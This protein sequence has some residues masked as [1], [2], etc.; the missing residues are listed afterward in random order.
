MRKTLILLLISV[1]F[2]YACENKK[3]E[4]NTIITNVGNEILYRSDLIKILPDEI[5]SNDSA[6][7]VQN[8]INEWRF[9]RLFYNEAI[10]NLE[11]TTEIAEKIK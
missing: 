7:F 4:D 2:L 5:S 3:V 11:D 8:Y 6:I 10:K 1:L 9:E